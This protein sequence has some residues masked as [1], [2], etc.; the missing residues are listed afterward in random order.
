M[1]IIVIALPMMIRRGWAL[2]HSERST[3]SLVTPTEHEKREWSRMAQAAYAAGRNDVG[4][5]Y[6]MAAT[7]RKGE[8]MAVARYDA[9]MSGYRAWLVFNAWESHDLHRCDCGWLA[10]RDRAL[11]LHAATCAVRVAS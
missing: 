1:V 3:M 9:L 11:F 10:R 8:R 6:S 7:L 5:P 2:R 4:H